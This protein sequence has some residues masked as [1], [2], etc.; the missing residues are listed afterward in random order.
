MTPIKISG[1]TWIRGT[2]PGVDVTFTF[3]VNP[4]WATV[5][6]VVALATEGRSAAPIRIRRSM[7]NTRPIAC[8][9]PTALVR[10]VCAS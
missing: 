9:V 6:P 8:P 10:L 7:P 4:V 2:K 5:I 3:G 1:R